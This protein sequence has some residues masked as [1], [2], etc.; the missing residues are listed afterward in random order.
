MS[1]VPPPDKVDEIGARLAVVR[2]EINEAADS[3]D[4][5]PDEITIV[6]VTKAFPAESVRAAYGLGLRH[7]G[8][9]RV[10]EGLSKIGEL[11]DLG[12]AAWHM[13]G[14]VQSRKA[15]DVAPGFD[16]VHSIDRLKIARKLHESRDGPPLPVLLQCNVS[17]E[18]SKYG[19]EL[20]D[21]SAWPGIVGEF[22]QISELDNLELRGLMTIAPWTRE[23]Q[24]LRTTFRRLRELSVFLAQAIPAV[25]WSEL[26]MGM[27]DDFP[28]AVEEG[29]TMLRLGRALFGERK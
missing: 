6:A 9:N 15:S 14:H 16:M 2:R 3:A 13:V 7:F 4:R 11:T 18:R 24:V 5:D 22:R 8:E 12:E 20:A 29:A 23:E 26:S 25:S 17:G 10:Q 1:S 28:I 21:R 19:W 27:T